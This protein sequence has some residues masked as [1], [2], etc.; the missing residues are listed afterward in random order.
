MPY[1]GLLYPE[2]L[3]LKQYSADLYLRRRYS[4]TVLSQSLG[5]FGSWCTHGLFEHSEH[6]WQIRGLILNWFYPSNCLVGAFPLPLDMGYLLKVAPA[7]RSCHYNAYPLAGASLPLDMRYLLKVAPAP[8]SHR[9]SAILPLK[10]SLHMDITRWSISNQIDYILCSQ[11]WKISIQLA[12]TRLEADCG[13]DHEHLIAKFRL[14]SKKVGTTTRSF[15][16]DL[17]QIPYNYTMKVKNRFKGLDLTEFLMN[18]GW[19]FVKLYR[20][21]WSRPSPRKR[22]AIRQNGCLTRPYK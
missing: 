10:K 9:S 13:S 21:Q 1:P 11:R 2:P 4:K 8:H 19:R 16:Y 6:L 15:R 17:N 22:N 7:P 3:P 18:Y 14:K 12:K 5:F 20:R